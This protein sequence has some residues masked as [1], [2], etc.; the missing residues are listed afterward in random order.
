EMPARRKGLRADERGEQRDRQELG[1]ALY[2]WVLQEMGRHGQARELERVAPG[3]P[4]EERGPHQRGSLDC[5][6]SRQP[7][8]TATSAAHST[9]RPGV[10]NG[11][12]ASATAIAP[13]AV[14]HAVRVFRRGASTATNAADAAASRP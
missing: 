2:A 7:A 12:S 5:L 6:G 3:R 14:I 10:N 4:D 13:N 8:T 11:V 9:G 1:D